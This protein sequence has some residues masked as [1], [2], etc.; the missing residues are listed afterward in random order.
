[1]NT[2]PLRNCMPHSKPKR[3]KGFPGLR[4]DDALDVARADAAAR[5]DDDFFARA[6]HKSA[7][8]AGFQNAPPG[9]R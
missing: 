6:P 9:R 5:H 2:F 3:A 8:A 1:M 7:S 4:G